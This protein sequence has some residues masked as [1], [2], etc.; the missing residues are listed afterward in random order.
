MSQKDIVGLT[1]NSAS[2]TLQEG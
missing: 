1:L 2:A